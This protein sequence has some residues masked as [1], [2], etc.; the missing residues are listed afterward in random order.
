MILHTT[1]DVHINSARLWHSL[2]E[3]AKIGPGVAGGNN[4]QSLTDEDA[5]GRALF[6]SWCEAAGL[7]VSID[8]MGSMFAH[9][10]GKN[11]DAL[12]VCI[13]SHLDT[14][15]TGGKFDGVLGVLAGLEVVRT[16][17][18]HDL[19]T[20]RPIIIANWTNEEGSRFVPSMLA[21]GVYANIYSLEYAHSR[22]DNTGTMLIDELKRTGWFGK[23]EVG[24]GNLHA[25][26]EYHIEQGPILENKNKSIGVVT[27][28]QG[29]SWIEVTLVGKEAHTGSTPMNMRTD[30]CLAMARIIDAVHHIAMSYQPNAAISVG[31]VNLFPNSR[32]ALP[33]KAIFTI[34]IR[35]PATKIFN[36]LK[37][38]VTN[39]ITEICASLNVDFSHE[40]IGEYEPIQFD[41]SLVN[42]VRDKANTLNYSHMDICS[43]AGHDAFWVSKVA[44]TTMIMCPCVG[45][46]SHSESESISEEWAMKGANL[47][48]HTVYEIASK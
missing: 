13:G 46:V 3:M 43:G 47:L 19:E 42:I 28:G 40:L 18:D 36:Q 31:Q 15:P 27:H 24:P 5:Q 14:Q 45:G 48:F 41:K 10:R 1:N 23:G 39:C 11:K 30:A 38:Q 2:M 16:L 35:S 12:P 20:V 22:L 32:N 26:V 44:P 37:Q 8:P 9:R 4:R 17:N 25:Y 34:D 21:S 7:N 29:Q 6:K 33:S